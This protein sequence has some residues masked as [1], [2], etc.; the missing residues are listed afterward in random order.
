MESPGLIA[1]WD[2]VAVRGEH[3]HAAYSRTVLPAVEQQM[4]AGDLSMHGLLDKLH[5]KYLSKTELDRYP[6]WRRS[7]F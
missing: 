2:A 4:A 1:G 7:F 5:V 3:L 6:D